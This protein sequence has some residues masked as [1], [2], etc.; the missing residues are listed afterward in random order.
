MYIRCTQ[1]AVDRSEKCYRVKSYSN[2]DKV[3]RLSIF[4]NKDVLLLF[5]T[6]PPATRAGGLA[7]I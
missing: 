3:L 2:D 4:Y 5:F 1:Q 7:A 6:V